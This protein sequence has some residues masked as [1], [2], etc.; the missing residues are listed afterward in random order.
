MAQ[1][2]YANLMAQRL[3][4]PAE[5]IIERHVTP[6]PPQPIF[7]QPVDL[8]QTVRQMGLSFHQ[9]FLRQGR[10]VPPPPPP[11]DE[12]PIQ[13][14][15]GG[16]PPPP[17]PGGQRVRAFGPVRKERPR[18]APYSSDAIVPV[19]GGSSS[20][21][22]A[23]Q[24]QLPEPPSWYTADQKLDWYLAHQQG[25]PPPQVARP[26]KRRRARVGVPSAAPDPPAAA[27]KRAA[28]TEPAP[29]AAPRQPP[30][31]E[32][33]PRPRMPPPILPYAGRGRQLDDLPRFTGHAERIGEAHAN[34]LRA[35]A[36]QRMREVGHQR[37][38]TRR[39]AE[40]LE[41]IRDGARAVR[42]IEGQGEVVPLGKRKRAQGG[43]P[44]F[45]ARQRVGARPAG[46]QQ[47]SLTY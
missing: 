42:R 15:G 20:A 33:A 8:S 3:Q 36:L 5:R 29:R 21:Q 40:M 11:S 35:A 32:P 25:R 1:Q 7:V 24:L 22:R 28:T 26:P 45:R 46:P 23:V 44:E 47:F 13:M 27:T 10:E 17:P 41:R 39:R 34:T 12:I 30:M 6:S 43:M 9:Y 4:S 14:L 37:G 16:G 31:P 38:Q 19:P 2:T 18:P